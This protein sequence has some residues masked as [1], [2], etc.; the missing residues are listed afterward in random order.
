MFRWAE[1]NDI[2]WW[3]KCEKEIFLIEIERYQFASPPV[4]STLR[5]RSYRVRHFWGL[6]KMK[7]G[8]RGDL[9]KIYCL[10]KLFYCENIEHSPLSRSSETDETKSSIEN[11][12]AQWT[13]TVWKKIFRTQHSPHPPLTRALCVGR[14]SA[15]RIRYVVSEPA[16]GRMASSSSSSRSSDSVIADWMW[17]F[18]KIFSLSVFSS[19]LPAAAAALMLLLRG[20]WFD[21]SIIISNVKLRRKI[22]H[23]GVSVAWSW[24]RERE[25]VR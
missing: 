22:Q 10:F 13:R 14:L 9:K 17:F 3:T 15:H 5:L 1:S 20:W 2:W 25:R 6:R 19:L 8:W 18:E 12:C 11:E 7:G 23:E 4:S 24:E 21:S 16:N